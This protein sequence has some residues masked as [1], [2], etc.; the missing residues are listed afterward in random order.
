MDGNKD[1]TATFT[2][3]EYTLDVTVVGGGGVTKNPATGPYY[4]DD[5]VTL[6]ATADP[7][8]TFSG[9]SG[10][11]S[12]S[13]NPL[14]V[15]MDGNKDV[16]ATFTQIEYTLDVTVVGGGGVT[17]NPA[18]GP[19]YYDDIVTLTATADPG[20]T[21]SGWSGDASGS[22]NPLPVTMDGNKDVTATFTQIE[23]TLDVTVV[24]GGGVTKNPATG[25]Y[26]YDDVV[27]LTAT[28]DPGWTFSGWSEDASGSSNPLPVTM[29]GNKDVTATF[30]QDEYTLDVTIVG[31][32]QVTANPAT[33][34]YF[35]GDVITLTATADP[36]WAFF[37]WSGDLIGDDNPDTLTV[38]GNT[39]VTATFSREVYRIF[40]PHVSNN[41]SSLP[42]LV[43]DDLL[44]SNSDIQV[45][46]LNRGRTPASNGFWV[47]GYIDP[48]PPPSSVND[49]WQAVADEGLVWGVTGVT[50]NPGQM[51]TLT[52]D[53]LYYD[54]SHSNFSG[55]IP[56]NTPVYAQ[57]DSAHAGTGYGAV[58]KSHEFAGGPYNNISSP[59]VPSL[60]SL[61]PLPLSDS[62]QQRGTSELPKRP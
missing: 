61:A 29:D 46:V 40:M 5:V 52:I 3:I 37:V 48:D 33:G 50:L 44:V 24:G 11:A 21:F 12:G 1:V 53:G 51:L 18:T 59:V 20:W 26:Y 25:P 4:Y 17:K 58:L 38:V 19:Y 49:I 36:D 35:Y 39:V 27:T 45:V 43:V 56:D 57:V 8:W 9:W 60:S 32:G 22:S 15:T 10:D 30:T 7:G 62:A 55:L 28:A 2:Q 16:T 47:D 31:N 14:P 42:D 41:A 54:A 6:T 34:P 23:Y 13:S